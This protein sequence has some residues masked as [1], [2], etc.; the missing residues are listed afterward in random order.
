MIICLCT[1]TQNLGLTLHILFNRGWC[2]RFHVSETSFFEVSHNNL[3]CFEVLSRLS[4]D[5]SRVKALLWDN[6]EL[7][8]VPVFALVSN[9][10]L[11]K[12]FGYFIP[13]FLHL[14]SRDKIPLS[15][16]LQSLISKVVHL[17]SYTF[18]RWMLLP[19]HA[20]YYLLDY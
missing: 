17:H 13:Q 12:Y 18:C 10:I 2:N 15:L 11:G 19:P 14:W 9:L 6:R 7:S 20:S 4:N 1:Y 16:P 8:A 5:Y 3:L